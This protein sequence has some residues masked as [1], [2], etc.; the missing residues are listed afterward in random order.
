L[1]TLVAA[2]DGAEGRR[3]AYLTSSG[4]DRYDLEELER[5]YFQHHRLDETLLQ[6]LQR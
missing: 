4:V 1:P 2:P 3:D 5:E 6:T